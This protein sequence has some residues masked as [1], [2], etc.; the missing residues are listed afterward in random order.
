MFTTD[1]QGPS[2]LGD[3]RVKRDLAPKQHSLLESKVHLNQVVEVC[4]VPGVDAIVRCVSACVHV[5]VCVCV[6]VCVH[7]NVNVY[8]YTC[9]CAC[10]RACV[11][12]CV[13]VR[14]RAH[15]SIVQLHKRRQRSNENNVNDRGHYPLFPSRVVLVDCVS[16]RVGSVSIRRNRADGIDKHHSLG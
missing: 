14:A 6:C 10:V 3:S 12:V 11:R 8:V 7:V 5:C 1:Y 2:V 13:C 9:V 15:K 4:C 16:C